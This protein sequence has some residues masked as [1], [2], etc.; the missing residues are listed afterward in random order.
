MLGYV[1]V[2]GFKITNDLLRLPFSCAEQTE[3]NYQECFTEHLL[4]AFTPTAS[5]I[6]KSGNKLAGILLRKR[7]EEIESMRQGDDMC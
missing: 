2:K 7:K 4:A 5:F 3:R 1:L 6:W